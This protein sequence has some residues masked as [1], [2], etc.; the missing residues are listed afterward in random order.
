MDHSATFRICSVHQLQEQVLIPKTP[1]LLHGSVKPENEQ[2]RPYAYFIGV[3][4]GSIIVIVFL[5][6]LIKHLIQKVKYL[7]Y[8]IFQAEIS[9]PLL[10]A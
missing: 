2:G 3:S 4:L 6:V 8:Q 10:Q 9:Q 1:P 5:I 7:P